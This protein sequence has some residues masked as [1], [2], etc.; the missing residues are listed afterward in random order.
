MVPARP[1][2]ATLRVVQ[3]DA[4]MSI[5]LAE[6]ACALSTHGLFA[7]RRVPERNDEDEID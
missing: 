6:T 3:K 7:Q 2:W 5:L 1:G 4:E